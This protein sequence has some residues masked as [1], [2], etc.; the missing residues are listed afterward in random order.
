MNLSH[1]QLI[2]ANVLIMKA[3]Q[4]ISGSPLKDGRQQEGKEL[5]GKAYRMD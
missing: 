5:M 3:W 4:G 2:L 1:L